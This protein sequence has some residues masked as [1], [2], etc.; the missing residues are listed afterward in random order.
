MAR[1]ITIPTLNDTIGRE[2]AE[3]YLDCLY[4]WRLNGASKV[5][6]V[7]LDEFIARR[8]EKSRYDNR[9]AKV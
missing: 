3:C 5:F 8:G 9:K 4:V 2:D 6:E 7:Y 1:E